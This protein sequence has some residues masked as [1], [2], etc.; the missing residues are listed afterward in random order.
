MP[1]IIIGM[2]ANQVAVKNTQEKILSY[3]QNSVD[4]AAGEGCMEEE[5]DLDILLCRTNLLSQ[6]LR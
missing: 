4:L 6:H 3:R 1:C 5:A 2:E